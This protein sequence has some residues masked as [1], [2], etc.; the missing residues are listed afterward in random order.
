MTKT[1]IDAERGYADER[2]CGVNDM[3]FQEWL[4]YQ[5]QMLRY[6]NTYQYDSG[7]YEEDENDSSDEDKSSEEDNESDDDN[8]DHVCLCDPID[9]E[10][11]YC[12]CDGQG[13]KCNGKCCPDGYDRW[14]D[15]REPINRQTFGYQVKLL[16]TIEKWLKGIISCT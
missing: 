8:D 5:G 14:L 4:C 9:I 1:T 12:C 2:L 11:G 15:S 3:T 10:A 7:L 13:K 16:S 6:Y